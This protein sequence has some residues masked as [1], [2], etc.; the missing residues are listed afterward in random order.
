MKTT[1]CVSIYNTLAGLAGYLSGV[2]AGLSV[3]IGSTCA[4]KLNGLI[5]AFELNAWCYAAEVF[6]SACLVVF[7]WRDVRISYIK[8]PWVIL[9][10]VLRDWSLI[11]G[12]G[13]A[14]KWENRGSE[15]FCA[16]PSRQG[17]TF[18]APPFKE[19]KLLRAPPTI[20]LK[21]TSKLFVPALQHG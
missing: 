20:W 5:P 8:V 6:L 7:T 4:Q 16:P 10:T 1:N 19:W 11:T 21:T 15:T 13:G 3:I 12:R 17:K 9:L 2:S 14:T 18:H